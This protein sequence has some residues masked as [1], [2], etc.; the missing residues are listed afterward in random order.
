MQ[1][2]TIPFS[3]YCEK[4]RWALDRAGLRYDESSHLP[5]LHV[6]ASLRA[7]GRRTVPVLKTRHG[8]LRDSTDILRWVDSLLDA[9]QRLFPPTPAGAEVERLEE[10]FDAKLGPATRRWAYS[11]LL[12]DAAR[13]VP[14]M[15]RNVPAWEP[16]A[17]RATLPA[18]VALM[19]KGMN[20]TPATAQ[21]SL[22]RTREL[23]AEASAL[24]DDGRP[25]LTGDRFTAADL[26]FAALATP[27]LF[28]PEHAR[29]LGSLDDIPPAMAD[30]VRA[31][32]ETPAGRFA[33]RLYRDERARTVRP[34][35]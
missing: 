30:E 20:I 6:I 22:E 4:A 19:R 28:P 11:H 8:T 33:M 1:L 2:V 12:D 3:H 24:L 25:Y 29:W 34:K 10:R 14:L 9:D 7:G 17:M 32:R 16:V 26:T 18:A 21:R 15:G 27:A 13:L 35:A 23:F 5:M 31:L